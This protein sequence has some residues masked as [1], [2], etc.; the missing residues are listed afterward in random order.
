MI[1]K[2]FLVGVFFLQT[3]SFADTKKLD[4]ADL[5]QY[6]YCGQDSDCVIVQNGCCDCANGGEDAAISSRH[7]KTFKARLDC[8]D[9]ACTERAA[10]PACGSGTVSCISGKCRYNKPSE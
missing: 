9:T 1:L 3:E 7:I 6:Q 8:L 5:A 10:I 2:I 4:A